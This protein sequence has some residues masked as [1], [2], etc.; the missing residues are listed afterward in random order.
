[1]LYDIYRVYNKNIPDVLIETIYQPSEPMYDST[2]L[3]GVIRLR[4]AQ[5]QKMD[6]ADIGIYADGQTENIGGGGPKI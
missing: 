1:M 4:V 5:Q 6:V 3:L 2:Q